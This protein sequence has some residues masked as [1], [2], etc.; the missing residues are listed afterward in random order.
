M[1]GTA[2]TFF[3][4]VTCSSAALGC[5]AAISAATDLYCGN[6]YNFVT[7]PGLCLGAALAVQQSG[8]AALLDLL[9]AAGFTVLLLFPFY[10]AG[11]LGAG[12]IKLLAAVSAFLPAGEYL[13]CF[14]GAFVIAAL[15]GLAGLV[16]TRGRK[17]TVHFA[18]PIA[19]SVFLH[20][21]G[22]Y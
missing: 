8:A 15:A 21:A 19:V 20:L 2:E 13:H 10:R 22:L 6:V 14:A 5:M 12:D 18:V 17:H 4:P 9:C 3:D 7:I 16:M 1:Y 11:G